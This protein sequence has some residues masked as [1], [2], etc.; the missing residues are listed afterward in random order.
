MRWDSSINN[1]YFKGM[2]GERKQE[3]KRT[4]MYE[5]KIMSR[6]RVNTLHCLYR[7]TRYL[8]LFYSKSYLLLQKNPIE[9]TDS[10]TG[11]RA[12]IYW[13]TPMCQCV[14]PSL[15]HSLLHLI[16]A[17]ALGVLWP[18]FLE[19]ETENQIHEINSPSLHWQMMLL[20]RQVCLAPECIIS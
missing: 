19:E 8:H 20:L 15:L 1:N 7:D 2:P 5:H 6:P 18:Q 14:C 12:N 13:E 9:M 16:L 3:K 11:D 17:R 4:W 10:S